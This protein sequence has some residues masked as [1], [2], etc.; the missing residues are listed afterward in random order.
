[1]ICRARLL[2]CVFVLN[3]GLSGCGNDGIPYIG[4]PDSSVVGTYQ[5]AFCRR[6][7]EIDDS[8]AAVI[9]GILVLDS[10]RIAVPD[11]QAEFFAF[12]NTAN[13]AIELSNDHPE[14]G[15]FALRE[16]GRAPT[17]LGGYAIVR[18]AIR[19]V[20][21]NNWRYRQD[22]TGLAFDID[23]RY[24]SSAEQN[25]VMNYLAQLKRDGRIEVLRERGANFHVFAFTD[26]VRP[27]DELIKASLVDVDP[28]LK[29][30]E[31]TNEKVSDTKTKLQ[32]TK[33]QAALKPS[34]RKNAKPR[35]R[36]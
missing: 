30:A 12:S 10:V 7:C 9:T 17:M 23:Y 27:P 6:A 34:A 33:R 21:L 26:G 5:L 13:W 11:S 36:R 1:M 32:K 16:P 31:N 14:A 28:S 15:C 3:A 24:M 8:A 35:K 4:T 19:A 2:T 18:D 20:G 29:D 25:F 22:S